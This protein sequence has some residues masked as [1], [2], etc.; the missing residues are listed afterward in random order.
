MLA[1][2]NH[3]CYSF[4]L[5]VKLASRYIIRSL[6]CLIGVAVSLETLAR[7]L[8]VP[9]TPLEGVGFDGRWVI[10]FDDPCDHAFGAGGFL[11]TDDGSALRVR[12]K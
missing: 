7:G 2:L 12:A 5:T 3:T 4:L 10:G 9:A 11:E 6:R 1:L 8:G